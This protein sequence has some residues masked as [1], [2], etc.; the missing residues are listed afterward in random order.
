M[1]QLRLSKCYQPCINADNNNG[2]DKRIRLDKV[3]PGISTIQHTWYFMRLMWDGKR[4][5]KDHYSNKDC[6]HMSKLWETMVMLL[7][8]IGN[9][10]GCHQIPERSFFWKGHQFPVCARCTGVCIGQLFAIIINIFVDIHYLIS[11]VFLIIMGTD[12]GIQEAG[13]KTS[14][15]SRR[16]ITGFL[17]GF[18]LFNLYLILIKKIVHYTKAKKL[19]N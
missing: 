5:T 14:N 12:W 7:Y 10:C 13:I 19:K 18:G 6:T 9:Q 11:V 3:M 2:K 4:K 1:S 8:D 15:N 16:F 17:G